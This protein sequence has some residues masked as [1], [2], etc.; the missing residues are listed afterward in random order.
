MSVSQQPATGDGDSVDRPDFPLSD[1][2][3][4]GPAGPGGE[5]NQRH[6][7]GEHHRRRRSHLAL[8]RADTST[9]RGSWIATLDVDRKHH[10]SDSRNPTRN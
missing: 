5:G 4:I 10:S 8:R 7:H 1:T 2:P 3:P 6:C 9:V